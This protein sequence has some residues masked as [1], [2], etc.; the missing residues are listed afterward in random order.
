MIAMNYNTKYKFVSDGTWFLKGAEC[1]VEDG[2]CLWCLGKSGFHEDQEMSYEFMMANKNRISGIFR[3]PIED[4]PDDGE[5]CGLDEFEII[6]I[7]GV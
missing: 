6:K 3:G 5:V 4:N 2:N 7:E 1:I